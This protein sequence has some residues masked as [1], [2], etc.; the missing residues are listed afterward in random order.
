MKEKPEPCPVLSH[1][2]PRIE[3]GPVQIG[4]NDWPG[5]FIRGD[6]ALYFSA[7][8]RNLAGRMPNSG[9]ILEAIDIGAVEGL[10]DLLGSCDVRKMRGEG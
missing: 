5:V 4:A 10:A 3:S 9:D 1:A 7:L 6:N 2:G 8:L